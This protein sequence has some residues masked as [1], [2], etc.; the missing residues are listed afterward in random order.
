ASGWYYIDSLLVRV[1]RVSAENPIRKQTLLRQQ[2]QIR[3]PATLY[4]G[5]P[6]RYFQSAISDHQRRWF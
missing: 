6:K 1:K 2:T 4:W 3:G 5:F